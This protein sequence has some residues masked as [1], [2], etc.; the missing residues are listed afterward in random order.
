M[1]LIAL[2]Q[3]NPETIT[4]LSIEQIVSNAGDG[5]LKDN[6]ECSVELREYL[7][8]TSTEKLQGYIDY[9]LS[10]SFST[11]GKVLQDLV[12]ELG[13]R[14]EYQ[15][16]NG[17][18]QGTKNAIGYDGYWLAPTG[19][20]LVVEI[21]TTDA[22][23]IKLDT[24]ANYRNALLAEGIFT[25]PSSILLVVGREDTGELEAQVRGSRHAWDIRLIS[26]DSLW[27][28]V[29]I[30]QTTDSPETLEKI[31]SLLAPFEYTKL[32]NLIDIMFT[33]AKDFESSADEEA[34]LHVPP[35]DQ[36]AQTIAP[37]QQFTDSAVLQAKRLE[38]ITAIAQRDNTHFVK[39]T[40]AMYWDASHS[41]RIVCTV[42]KRYQATE[43]Y[44][45]A[46]HPK[47][48]DFLSAGGNAY[49]ALGCME[50]DRAF[51]IPY[52]TLHSQL[53]SLNTTTRDNGQMY[54]H[55]KIIEREPSHYTLQLPAIGSQMALDE[56]A[57]E[58]P[59]QN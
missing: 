18:Y 17:R 29:E 41:T 28:L 9:C 40:R 3:T 35:D 34:P 37:K 52:E 44:W 54:W 4:Q 58:L 53:E 31:R 6:T 2:W 46:Y 25:D 43:R 24:L 10:H 21:K 55:I 12:N 51:A 50:L 56:Y 11:G 13:R 45:Y 20:N 22:Y 19:H 14:L 26:T 38:V 1:P 42:S 27:E 15:V 59:N 16:T 49:F 8:Q 30:K 23:R 47:W 7:S 5:I 32:D 33:A 36:A 48:D 39:R 57:V